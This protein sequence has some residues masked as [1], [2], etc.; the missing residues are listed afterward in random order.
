MIGL[1][2]CPIV[3][4]TVFDMSTNVRHN[5]EHFK[6]FARSCFFITLTI[7]EKNVTKLRRI[8]KWMNKTDSKKF[9]FKKSR[10]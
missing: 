2:L 1:D 7:F 3:K 4:F 8:S 10:S 9:E 5:C 6:L